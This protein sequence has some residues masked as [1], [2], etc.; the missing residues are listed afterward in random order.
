M[1][2]NDSHTLPMATAAST[3][4]SRRLTALAA[5]AARDFVYLLA[6]FCVSIIELVVWITGFALT[7]GLL[8]LII[9][10][11]VWVATA[12]TFRGMAT[13]DRRLAGWLR[14]KPIPGLYQPPRDRS[15]VRTVT[16]DPQ[17]WKDF[18]WM[19]LNSIGG[20]VVSLIG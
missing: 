6:V 16:T 3:A 15:R 7:I 19:V 2:M 13:I 17:T 14:G 1:A 11:F 20:F 8:V 18:G 9:G 10:L 5:S 12:Y 4:N